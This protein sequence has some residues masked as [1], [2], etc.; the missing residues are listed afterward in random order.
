[1]PCNADYMEPNQG[2]KNLGKV[3]CLLDEIKS[4]KFCKENFNGYHIGAYMKYTKE[5]LD[6]STAELCSILKNRDITKYSLE[7][8]IWWRDHQEADRKR[9]RDEANKV[10]EGRERRNAL[11]KLTPA[12]RKV[13]G[14]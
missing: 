8:Q 1:M 4:G 2:E 12:E 7:L 5:K 3:L 9:E 13:L 11:A 10:L 14:V 6:K